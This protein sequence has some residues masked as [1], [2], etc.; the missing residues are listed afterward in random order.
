[1]PPE[2]YTGTPPAAPELE[3]PAT[4]T[5]ASDDLARRFQARLLV[6]A[7]R[8]LRNRAA[9][10]DVVQE[11]LRRVLE[12][13]QSGRLR[14]PN[15]LPAFVFETARHVCQ[16]LL[17]SSQREQRALTRFS[18]QP[19]DDQPQALAALISEEERARVR[20]CFARLGDDDRDVLTMTFAEGLETKEIAGRL[21]I[22]PGAVRVRRHRALGRLAE[23][24]GET[25]RSNREPR[26]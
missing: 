6:F 25:N 2:R 16:R 12:A 11:T 1:M 17:R 15:A 9:A 19:S 3:G 18:A 14:N 22:S 23:L 5:V 21:G 4:S 13:L 10:E 8:R 26:K 20:A 24:M 7:A